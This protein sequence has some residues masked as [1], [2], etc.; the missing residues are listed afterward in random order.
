MSDAIQRAREEWALFTGQE[1]AALEA[2]IK[3]GQ[4]QQKLDASRGTV[5]GFMTDKETGDFIFEIRVVKADKARA[6]KDFPIGSKVSIVRTSK[7]SK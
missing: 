7:V 4:A 2:G 5:D 3:L 6:A 1:S